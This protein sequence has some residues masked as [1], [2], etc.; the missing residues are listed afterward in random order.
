MSQWVRGNFSM[1]VH[2]LIHK[3]HQGLLAEVHASSSDSE[4]KR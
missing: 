1:K 3:G 4:G 2:L